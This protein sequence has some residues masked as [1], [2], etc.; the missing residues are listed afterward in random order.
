MLIITIM[1]ILVLLWLYFSKITAKRSFLQTMKL[2]QGLNVH[3][4]RRGN[5]FIQTFCEGQLLNRIGL[6]P[7]E[8]LADFLATTEDRNQHLQALQKA[9]Q[10]ESTQYQAEKNGIEFEMHLTP[11]SKGGRVT[12]VIGSA[13]DISK[14]RYK[15]EILNQNETWYRNLFSVMSEGAFLYGADDQMTVL[16]DSVFRIFRKD[17]SE[18]LQQTISHLTIPFI[19]EDGRPLTVENSPIRHTL[20]TGEAL[21]GRILGIQEKERTYWL[22]INTKLL[23]TDAHLTVPQ[24]LVTVSDITIQ[25]EQQHKLIESNALRRTIIDSLPMGVMVMDT[26]MNIMAVNRTYLCMFG[27]EDPIH[28]LIGRSI[29]SFF[30]EKYEEIYQVCSYQQPYIK[31]IAWLDQKI[32]NLSYFPFYMDGTL[33]GHLWTVVDIT[34][35]K[36]M[37]TGLLEAKEEAE[38]ANQT[39]SVFLSNMSHELRTPLNGILGFSQL[40]EMDESL[41]SVQQSYVQEILAGGRHL[42]QLINKILDLSRI[43]AGKMA[44]TL[45]SVSIQACIHECIRLIRPV[46]ERKGIRI[47]KDDIPDH[48]EYVWADSIR[49]R[50]ILLNL[51]DNAVKYNRENGTITISCTVCDGVLNVRISDTGIGIIPAEQPRIFEPFYRIQNGPIEGTGIGLSLVR[52]LAE[53]M[54]G[55]TGVISIPGEGSTFWVSLPLDKRVAARNEE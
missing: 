11:I 27:I 40:L 37:E 29:G 12:Q 42:L 13:V 4:R 46:A 55:R 6:S 5:R 34:K 25:Y 21:L 39:K 23:A 3:Y 14:Q 28:T 22:S 41:G 35:R 18:F 53:L 45:E 20:D 36:K 2:Q 54:G 30:P 44:V 16:N 8:D 17:K 7:K 52:Q 24:V 33:L 32:F 31:E 1:L 49:I 19:E 10:G 43:E 51:L 9:F 47:I 50:Q 38:R 48:H 15:D 26:D